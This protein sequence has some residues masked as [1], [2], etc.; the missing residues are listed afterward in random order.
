LAY[1]WQRLEDKLTAVYREFMLTAERSFVF[2]VSLENVL[3]CDF[4]ELIL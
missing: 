4:D 3:S 1:W 2:Q